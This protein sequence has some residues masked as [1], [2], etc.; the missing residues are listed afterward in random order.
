MVR[1]IT[2]NQ[3]KE[4]PKNISEFSEKQIKEF[5]KIKNSLSKIFTKVNLSNKKNYLYD[6]TMLNY[7][8][9]NNHNTIFVSAKTQIGFEL[10][11]EF[12][13]ISNDNL[14]KVPS[15]NYYAKEGDNMSCNYSTYLIKPVLDILDN[16][17][18]LVKSESVK[19]S[20]LR[21]YPITLENNHLRFIVAPKGEDYY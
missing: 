15:L 13:D 17:Q 14:Q 6:D 19:I 12:L 1:K 4:I 8:V 18:I 20:I 3:K 16:F 7:G 9:L 10:L 11:K 2:E 5:E 21:D